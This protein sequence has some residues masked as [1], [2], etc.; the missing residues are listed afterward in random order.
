MAPVAPRSPATG[1][2]RLPGFSLL[3]LLVAVVIVAIGTLGVARLQ[4]HSAQN[5]RAALQRSVAA[6]LAEDV[7]ERLH[8]NPSAAYAIGLGDPPPAYVDC[9]GQTC[10]RAQLAAF[11]LAVWKCALGSWH[12]AAPCAPV[13]AAGI[14][15]SAI[16]QPG[17]AGGDGAVEVLPGGVVVTVVWRSAGQRSLRLASRLQTP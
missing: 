11:D 5:N 13:R 1:R 16:R 9:L 17:L 12:D 3:E 7:L 2:R 6:M 15:D 14:L 10:D 8:A 4:L